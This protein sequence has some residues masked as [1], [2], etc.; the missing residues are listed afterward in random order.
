MCSAEQVSTRG[1]QSPFGDAGRGVGNALL[2]AILDLADNWLNLKRV[3]LD[4]HVD[5]P[6]AIHLYK[7]FGFEIEG[8]RRFHT[9]GEGGWIDSYFMG[10]VRVRPE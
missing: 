5:N 4:V 6:A 3:E 2:E 9:Y 7:K 10:R 8:R 1:V